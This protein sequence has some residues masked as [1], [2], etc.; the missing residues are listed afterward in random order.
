MKTE[1]QKMIDEELYLS[2][3]PELVRMRLDCR[4]LLK[5][6]NGSSPADRESR[7]NTLKQL[8]PTQGD[9][10]YIEPPF[11]CDYGSNIEVGSN[12]YM[13][14]NCVFLDVA[15]IIVGDDVMFAP[16]VQ[17]YTATHP[18][19]YK[20]RMSGLELGKTIRIGSGAWIGGGAII[21]PGINIG[22]RSVIGAGSVVTK[23]I[24]DDVLA[25]GNPCKVIKQI[26]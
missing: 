18:L 19:N 20:E 12:V 1:F 25:V 16:N 24:P 3:D 23:D 26:K 10:F 2:D 22:E 8:V 15:K 9:G 11:Y 4:L 14:F 6:F 21:N 13:N 5:E 7:K 17:V